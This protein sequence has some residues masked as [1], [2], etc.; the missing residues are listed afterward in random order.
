MLLHLVG[1][2]KLSRKDIKK[3]KEMLSE[4]EK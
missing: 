4:K 3:L 1:E 2:A